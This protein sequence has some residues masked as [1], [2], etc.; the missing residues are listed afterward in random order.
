MN[1]LAHLTLAQPSVSSKVGN[2]L[3]D[4]MRGV[5]V[6]ALPAP[7]RQG[8]DNHRLVD[9]FTDHHDW[10]LAQRRAFSPSR[11]RF[12]GVALDVLF[13]HFLWQ[14]WSTFH[15]RPRDDTIHLHYAQ[16]QAGNAL[17]PDAMRTRMQAMVEQDWLN[18]YAR[19]EQVGQALDMIASRIRF[20][21]GFA[22]IV[23]EIAPRYAELEAGFLVF[24][25]Q[26]QETVRSAG[27]E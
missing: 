6:Q 24:Y 13:D 17:M 21:N 15:D 25:P 5:D 2:M 14:H 22:G 11:R 4:F 19:L 12:A 8:L 10:V 27:L 16:L 18:R 9:R 3:G 23:E 26:L 1:Y 20:A 7:V